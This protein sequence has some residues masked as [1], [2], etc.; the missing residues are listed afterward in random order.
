MQEENQC[1]FLTSGTP[2]PT[3]RCSPFSGV[4][5][6]CL[7]RRNLRYARL[8]PLPDSLDKLKTWMFSFPNLIPLL[9]QNAVSFGF[10]HIGC[11]TVP[12]C[13]VCD[14]KSAFVICLV[15]PLFSSGLKISSANGTSFWLVSPCPV[16]GTGGK[17][18]EE[19]ERIHPQGK[20]GQVR[21]PI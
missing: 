16:P 5:G 12:V 1:P 19:A 13:F 11:V 4:S 3:M 21:N 20:R 9:R 8:P 18:W 2:A 15:L 17:G 7:R 14:R 6:C 10:K